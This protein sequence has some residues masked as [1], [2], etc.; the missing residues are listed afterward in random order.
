M[1]GQYF[2][3]KRFSRGIGQARPVKKNPTIDTDTLTVATP[4]PAPTTRVERGKG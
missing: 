1:F 3:E 2:L 4:S